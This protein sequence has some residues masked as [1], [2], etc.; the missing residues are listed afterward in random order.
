MLH[1]NRTT[2]YYSEK[3]LK[4]AGKE[5]GGGRDVVN[6]RTKLRMMVNFLL[7]PMQEDIFKILKEKNST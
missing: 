3:I 1:H 4:V 6:R 7:E 5:S 2:Q